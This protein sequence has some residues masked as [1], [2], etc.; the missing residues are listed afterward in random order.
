MGRMK[1]RKYL[2]I[3]DAQAVRKE[4]SEYMTTSSWQVKVINPTPH[5]TIY[6]PEPKPSCVVDTP[7][8]QSQPV[9]PPDIWHLPDDPTQNVDKS[10]HLSDPISTPD[11]LDESSTLSVSDDYLL[12]LDTA[13]PS[14]ELQTNSSVDCVNSSVDCVEIEFLVESEGQLGHANHSATDVFHEHHTKGD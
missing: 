4:Y 13:S 5:S 8:H 12:H 3:T 10:C 11:G 9:H 6:N 2:K 7:I 1:V 14:S